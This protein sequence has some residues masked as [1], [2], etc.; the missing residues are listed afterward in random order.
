MK[1][2][3]TEAK[4]VHDKGHHALEEFQDGNCFPLS[5]CLNRGS[6][7]LSVVITHLKNFTYLGNCSPQNSSL[8]RGSFELIVVA[9]SRDMFDGVDTSKQNDKATTL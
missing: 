3:E 9:E 6:L 5:S 7:E 2:Y 1:D 8:V 4:L